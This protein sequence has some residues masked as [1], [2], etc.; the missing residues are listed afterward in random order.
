MT[1]FG[2]RPEGLLSLL[3]PILFLR[4]VTQLAWDRAA[5]RRERM[6]PAGLAKLC[7]W[8]VDLWQQRLFLQ[9]AAHRR[10]AS[11]WWASRYITVCFSINWTI[12]CHLSSGLNQSWMFAHSERC[13]WGPRDKTLGRHFHGEKKK[14]SPPAWQMGREARHID[15]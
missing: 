4:V 6:W 9:P 11:V 3:G 14:K 15:C 7:T 8:E 1:D 12:D 2:R 13:G 5:V 10:N